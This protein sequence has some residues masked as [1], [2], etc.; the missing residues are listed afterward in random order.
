MRVFTRGNE[1]FGPNGL[2]YGYPDTN[3]VIVVL[4]HAGQANDE[5][6]WSRLVHAKIEKLLM[7]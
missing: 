2:I 4:T 1:D 7:L 5:I 6:S 3:T